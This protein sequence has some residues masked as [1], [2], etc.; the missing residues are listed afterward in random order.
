MASVALGFAGK[1]IGGALGGPIGAAIG[2]AIGSAIGGM[3]DN[4]LFPMKTEGP[5]L[6]DL[7]VQGSTYGQAIPKLFGSNNR[8]A[9]NVIWT[10]GLIETS[11][12]VKS[13]GKGGPTVSQREYSYR[14]SLAVAVGAGP[15]TRIK[16]AWA[17]GKL[18]YDVDGTAS[19]P[20]AALRYYTGSFTQLPDPTIESFLGMGNVPAYRG[21]AYVVLVDLQLADYGNRLPNMEFLIEANPNETAGTVAQAI[22]VSAG[23]DRNT[24][25]F[26][27]LE[28]FQIKGFYISSPT[29]GDAALQPLSMAYNFDLAEQAG[30]LRFTV[31]GSAPEAIIPL[32]DLGAGDPD[33][34]G[35]EP[36]R[37]SREVEAALP[38]QSTVTFSDAERDFQPNSQSDVRT[39]GTADNNLD[40]QLAV[41]LSPD[42]GRSIASRAL[43]EAW[44]GRQ[45]VTS[46]VTDKWKHILAG[47]TYLIDTPAGLEPVRLI[48]RTRG[49]NGVIE[50]ELKRENVEVYSSSVAGVPSTVPVNQISAPG[51][52]RTV[53]LDIPLLLD[54]DNTTAEGFYFGAYAESGGWRGAEILMSLDPSGATQSLGMTGFELTI[55]TGQTNLIAIPAGFNVDT[56]WDTTSVLEVELARP[57]MTLESMADAEVL[58]GGNAAYIGPVSGGTGEIIQF[59]NVT[60]LSPTRWALSRLRRGQKG[61]NTFATAHGSAQRFVLLEPGALQRANLG[62]GNLN[63]IR[64]FRAVSF[65]T[66][67][68]DAPEVSFTNTGI[69]LRPYSPTS[70]AVTGAALLDKTLTFVRRSRVGWPAQ[71]PP[72][73][74]EEVEE[75]RLQIMD[76]ATV[77]R[78]VTLTATTT[79]L[80]TVAMQTTDFGAPVTTLTWRVAQRSTTFGYGP[81]AVFSGPV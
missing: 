29:S 20:F 56:T 43:W 64:Y 74:A 51:P 73:L 76:G 22:A 61:T 48:N 59:A 81:N 57:G 31:R 78:T 65:L 24:I 26:A 2:G 75:F 62:F 80:Y 27:H 63:Q 33:S 40:I 47:R 36:L 72:P 79:F 38:R 34:L 35:G 11:R 54:A 67:A 14:A 69:G 71:Q 7:S 53:L 19:G 17:N 30:A 52:S 3:V 39:S 8:I 68:A 66:S 5:R 28:N 12:K 32:D 16:K 23:I 58:V 49:V 9:G 13:G 60:Q 21:T 4:T 37:W 1:A 46:A 44:N 6:T 15:T 45:S 18:I 25:S 50:I 77:K 70:L 41:V 42:E 10:S 55:G